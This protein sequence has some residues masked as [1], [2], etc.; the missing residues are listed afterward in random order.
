MSTILDE[1]ELAK[2]EPSNRNTPSKTVIVLIVLQLLFHLYCIVFQGELNNSLI[3]VF[4]LLPVLVVYFLLPMFL[5]LILQLFL[6]W[7][8]G[9][10]FLKKDRGFGRLLHQWRHQWDYWVVLIACQSVIS[11]LFWVGLN[12]F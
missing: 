3:L 12:P 4:V 7:L 9:F 6:Y 1:P 2:A 8:A 10:S 5:L 11:L